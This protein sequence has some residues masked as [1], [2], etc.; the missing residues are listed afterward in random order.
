MTAYV[1]T[2]LDVFDIE[3]YLAYQHAL[4]PLLEAVGARYLARGGEFRVYQGD[5][6]PRRLMVLEFPSLAAVDDF[7]D[8]PGYQALEAQRR[9]CSSARIIAVDGL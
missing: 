6:L 7:Y 3:Q 1:V 2:D 9:A 8:S 4:K 5:Y